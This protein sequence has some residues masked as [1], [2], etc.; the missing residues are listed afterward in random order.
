MKESKTPAVRAFAE[1]GVQILPQLPL[2]VQ[3]DLCEHAGKILQAAGLIE[4]A[5]RD[6]GRTWF[7]THAHRLAEGRGLSTQSNGTAIGMRIRQQII[8]Q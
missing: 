6:R 5:A 1:I 7:G 3:T 4:R 8:R 2:R